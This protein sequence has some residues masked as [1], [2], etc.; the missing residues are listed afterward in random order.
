MGW[1]KGREWAGGPARESTLARE[2]SQD[3]RLGLDPKPWPW[4]SGPRAGLLRFALPDLSS[5]N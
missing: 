5:P 2:W 1:G 3:P 4:P